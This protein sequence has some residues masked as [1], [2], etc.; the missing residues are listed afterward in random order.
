M[1]SRESGELRLRTLAQAALRDKDSKLEVQEQACRSLM[2]FVMC[3]PRQR[4]TAGKTV[5]EMASTELDAMVAKF[6]K[7]ARTKYDKKKKKK[8]AGE[9]ELTETEAKAKADRK[10]ARA[11]NKRMA[12]VSRLFVFVACYYVVLYYINI[13]FFIVVSFE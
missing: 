10:R 6:I 8:K 5:A 13:V 11:L 4:P 12:G 3:P 1:R 7:A 2:A 9:E